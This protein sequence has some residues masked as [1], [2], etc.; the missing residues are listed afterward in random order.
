MFKFLRN[1]GCLTV[2]F[3][4]IF[5]VIS[6]IYGGSKIREIGDKTSGMLKKGFHYA[7]QRADSIHKSFH[8]YFQKISKS[9]RADEKKDSYNKKP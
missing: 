9:L 3:L 8:E 7:A 1:L 5:L 6:I 2:V 4:L